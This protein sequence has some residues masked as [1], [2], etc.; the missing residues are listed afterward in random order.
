[1]RVAFAAVLFIASTVLVGAEPPNAKLEKLVEEIQQALDADKR[2]AR[3]ATIG[4]NGRHLLVTLRGGISGGDL[5]QIESSLMQLAFYVESAPLR[6]RCEEAA[7]EIRASREAKDKQE[8]ADVTALLQR[9]TDAIRSA[10]KP[11]DLDDLL[12]DLGAVRRN[13]ADQLPSLSSNA[14]AWQ[15]EP[16]FSS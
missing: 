2:P 6:A 1:M 14:V 10:K 15:I 4:D 5:A 9:A 11:S 3:P 7:R 13:R 12:R 8:R 16:A